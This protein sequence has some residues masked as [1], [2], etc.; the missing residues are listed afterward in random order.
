MDHKGFKVAV[1]GNAIMKYLDGDE[2]FCAG[3]AL[4]DPHRLPTVGMGGLLCSTAVRAVLMRGVPGYARAMEPLLCDALLK[5]INPSVARWQ[6]KAQV[7]QDASFFPV[8]ALGRLLDVAL[9]AAVAYTWVDQV[10][11]APFR[12]SGS[13]NCLAIVLPGY[14]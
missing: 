3:G 1:S 6:Q 7:C 2:G 5:R 10:E 13:A 14:E 9:P 11:R 8:D 4:V 12:E